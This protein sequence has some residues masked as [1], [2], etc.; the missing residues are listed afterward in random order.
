[1]V[2]QYDGGVAP[3]RAFVVLLAAALAVNPVLLERCAA[4]C[5]AAAHDSEPASDCHDPRS[6]SAPGSHAAA[7][8]A[9]C[10]HDHVSSGAALGVA[11]DPRVRPALA[12]PRLRHLDMAAV[13]PAAPPLRPATGRGQRPPGSTG[14]LRV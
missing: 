12:I 7:P 8:Q 14:P 11:G 13:V 6:G 10:G 4:L 2:L 9:P 1:V 5:A 3:V